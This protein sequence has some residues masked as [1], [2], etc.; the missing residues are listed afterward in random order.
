M[1]GIDEK[2]IKDARLMLFRQVIILP[3]RFVRSLI[4]LP[5]LPQSAIFLLK[6][7]STWFGYVPRLML[8]TN[9]ILGFYYPVAKK[10]NDYDKQ[11]RYFSLS[12]RFA[13]FAS[14]TG[15]VVGIIISYSYLSL[16]YIP[17]LLVW[18][19]SVAPLAHI[20]SALFAKGNFN[21]IA[22]ID[23]LA[24]VANFIL[25]L[26]GWFLFEFLGYIGGSAISLALTIFIGRKEIFIRTISLNRSFVK[27]NVKKGIHFWLNGFLQDLAKSFEITLFAIIPSVISKEYGGQYAV[28]MTLTGIVNQLIVSLSMVLQRKVTMQLGEGNKRGYKHLLDYMAIDIIVFVVLYII[29]IPVSD[30]LVFFLP[31]YSLLSEI[32]PILLMGMFFLRLRYYPGLDFKIKKRFWE[33]HWGHI[34]HLFIVISIVFVFY[35]KIELPRYLIAISQLSG[36][37]I[38]TLLVLKLFLDNN[39]GIY[40]RSIITAFIARMCMLLSIIVVHFMIENSVVKYITEIIIAFIIIVSILIKFPRTYDI[41]KQLIGSKISKL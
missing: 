35:Y 5:L 10:E 9:A 33:I 18:G 16:A 1:K 7:I 21:R 26:V 28:A 12:W 41:I 23:I 11:D 27:K 39:K 2:D 15:G 19:L 22:R 40:S 24:A 34:I 38:G 25:P 4:I 17:F 20:N 8:G 29:F 37:L 13:L 14:L 30:I 36:A 32:L 3:L 31:N 6:I